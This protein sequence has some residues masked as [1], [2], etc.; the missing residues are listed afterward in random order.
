MIFILKFIIHIDILAAMHLCTAAK[1][2]IC[3]TV[4]KIL[5]YKN[6]PLEEDPKRRLCN[7]AIKIKLCVLSTDAFL[8]K[9]EG[10]V[11]HLCRVP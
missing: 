7:A 2:T 10:L 3:R 8:F 11:N 1:M 4:N 5:C 9:R 6:N